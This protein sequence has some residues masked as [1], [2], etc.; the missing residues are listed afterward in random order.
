MTQ[1]TSG[2]LK[3]IAIIGGGPTGAALGTLLAWK[4]RTSNHNLMDI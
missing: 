2:N 4:G 1:S 3:T